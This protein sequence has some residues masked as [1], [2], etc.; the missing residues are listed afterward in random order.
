M[1]M[2][3]TSSVSVNAWRRRPKARGHQRVADAGDRPAVS[4]SDWQISPFMA[5]DDSGGN[6]SAAPRY[7]QI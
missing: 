1:P 4:R 7:R 3:T 2:E 6:L 5:L